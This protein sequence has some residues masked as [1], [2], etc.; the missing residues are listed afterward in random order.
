VGEDSADEDDEDDEEDPPR[1]GAFGADS[2]APPDGRTE[3]GIRIGA[4]PDSCEETS[5]A[6]A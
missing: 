1:A 5:R 2:G 4:G 6:V 3:S